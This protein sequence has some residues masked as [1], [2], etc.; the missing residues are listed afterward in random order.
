MTAQIRIGN[1]P[2][3]TSSAMSGGEKGNGAPLDTPPTFGG[4]HSRCASF[5]RRIRTPSPG[6]RRSSQEWF[7]G[8]QINTNSCDSN[9]R[10]SCICACPS[11]PTILPSTIPHHEPARFLSQRITHM[12]GLSLSRLPRPAFKDQ[13]RTT[14]L[15]LITNPCQLSPGEITPNG[16]AIPRGRQRGRPSQP[17]PASMPL[18]A[19][20]S[21]PPTNG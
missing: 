16:K 7:S 20:G 21:F 8:L 6:Q 4:R 18:R 15:V 1:R 10:D 19:L 13:F 12:R 17:P 5:P 11:A 3:R 14:C 2:P 9:Q